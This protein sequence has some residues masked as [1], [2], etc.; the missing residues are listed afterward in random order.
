[1]KKLIKYDI[2][3]IISQFE[4]LGNIR[5]FRLIGAIV[6]YTVVGTTDR[7]PAV[8]VGDGPAGDLLAEALMGADHSAQMFE[9]I[10]AAQF[11][12]VHA[13]VKEK[14]DL[15]EKE[16]IACL[17]HEIDL[18]RIDSMSDRLI[19]MSVRLARLMLGL[20]DD[21]EALAALARYAAP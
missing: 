2:I 11:M 12:M 20:D 10:D 9:A 6:R 5:D 4:I 17:E 19:I 1:L 14:C 15:T 21:Q 8:I 18:H 13:L 7:Y 16:H 3:S